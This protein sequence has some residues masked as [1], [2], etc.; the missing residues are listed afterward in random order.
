MVSDRILLRFALAMTSL[1]LWKLSDGTTEYLYAFGTLV[2]L[3]NGALLWA[4]EGK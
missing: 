1:A 2:W 4:M 3:A